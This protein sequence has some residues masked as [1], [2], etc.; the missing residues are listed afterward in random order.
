ME[1]IRANEEPAVANQAGSKQSVSP[2][3]T[4]QKETYS[5]IEADYYWCGNI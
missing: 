1:Y 5:P 4:P 3:Q 2:A